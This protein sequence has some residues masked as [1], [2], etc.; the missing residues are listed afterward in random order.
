M[1]KYGTFLN[2]IHHVSYPSR[3]FKIQALYTPWASTT[4]KIMVDPIPMIKT[5]RKAMVVILTSIVLMVVGI[6]GYWYR[7]NPHPKVPTFWN[8]ESRSRSSKD[9][10]PSRNLFG[11]GLGENLKGEITHGKWRRLLRGAFRSPSFPGCHPPPKLSIRKVD[12]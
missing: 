11:A 9:V 6:S 12:F 2:Q 5:L 4:I 10:S 7:F 8:S 1:R 3:G